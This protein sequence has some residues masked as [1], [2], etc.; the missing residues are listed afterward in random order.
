MTYLD[1]WSIE[2]KLLTFNWDHYRKVLNVNVYKDKIYHKLQENPIRDK[3]LART[4]DSNKCDNEEVFE[5]LRLLWKPGFIS[6]KEF[7]S[8]STKE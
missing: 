1:R 4:L 3:I 6:A 8:I 7:E 2:D 5:F